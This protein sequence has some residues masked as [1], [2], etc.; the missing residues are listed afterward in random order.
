[1]HKLF[2]YYYHPIRRYEESWLCEMLFLHF[3]L[4]T[5]ITELILTFV[6]SG[7]R[8]DINQFYDADQQ[9]QK[10]LKEFQH[11]RSWFC[12]DPMQG[13]TYDYIFDGAVWNSIDFYTWFSAVAYKELPYT[14][15][16]GS[17]IASLMLE[18]PKLRQFACDYGLRV[19]K[20]EIESIIVEPY[21]GAATDGP[22]TRRF[23]REIFADAVH[24]C[25]NSVRFYLYEKYLDD[26]MA[27]IIIY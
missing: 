23:Y 17:A 25:M 14:F 1:M 4:P 15:Q 24:Y 11:V 3:R 9:K 19:M 12:G 13:A 18:R 6:D 5:E 21:H 2:A 26:V 8:T 16:I 10:L 22:M 20:R 27:N 7:I